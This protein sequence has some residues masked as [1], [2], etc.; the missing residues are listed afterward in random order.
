IE[1]S[2]EKRCSTR[3]LILIT[4]SVHAGSCEVMLLF[5]SHKEKAQGTQTFQLQ[6]DDMWRC[7][8]DKTSL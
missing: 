4:Y 8:K 1:T 7:R 3:R 6:R 5:C 2:Y